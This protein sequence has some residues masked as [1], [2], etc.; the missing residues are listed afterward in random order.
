MILVSPFSADHS[1]ILYLKSLWC[2][3]AFQS[4]LTNTK[5][6]GRTTSLNL[7][8]TVCLMQPTTVLDFFAASIWRIFM[9]ALMCTKIT[10]SFSA[11][12]LYRWVAPSTDRCLGLFLPMYWTTHEAPVRSFLQTDKGLPKD[13][14]TLWS[15]N[16][17]HSSFVFSAVVLRVHMFD[18]PGQ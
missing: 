9:C 18:H 14:T 4:A 13:R 17:S 3:S 12:Q 7:H 8:S 6:G 1:M 15:M 10:R 5:K 16:H 11:E 2:C